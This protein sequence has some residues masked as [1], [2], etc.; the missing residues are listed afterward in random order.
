MERTLSFRIS[1]EESSSTVL[2]H[3]A[4]EVF[5]L[6]AQ[7]ARRICFETTLPNARLWHFDGPDLYQLEC[8]ISDGRDSHRFITI[9]GVRKIWD[10][11]WC[12]S[13]PRLFLPLISM[14]IGYFTAG[15]TTMLRY[16][17]RPF[18]LP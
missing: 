15:V 12:F 11:R 3:A 2:T 5:S 4:S 18:S 10:S 17:T 8:S 14:A 13:L 7:T 16:A 9:F 6:N 1:E